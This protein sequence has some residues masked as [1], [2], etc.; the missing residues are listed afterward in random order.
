MN[1]M[2]HSRLLAGGMVALILAD[3][4]ERSSSSAPFR[5]GNS[6]GAGN[7]I[8]AGRPWL[9]HAA[10]RFVCA[11][12]IVEVPR[13]KPHKPIDVS[14]VAAMYTNADQFER[15]DAAV[16]HVLSIPRA[17]LLRREA[18]YKRVAALNPKRRGPKPKTKE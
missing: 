14:E 11:N 7:L 5:D 16:S 1:Y 10:C 4:T 17:E 3:T 18:E 8:W 12:Q 6:C 13:M 2:N 15:F 9:V